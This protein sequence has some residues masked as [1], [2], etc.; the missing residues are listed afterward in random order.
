MF[1]RLVN[2]YGVRH[3]PNRKENK[4]M[5]FTFNDPAH[6]L[7]IINTDKISYASANGELRSGRKAP[8][9]HMVGAHKVLTMSPDDFERLAQ[10]LEKKKM[11]QR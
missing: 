2:K 6:G 3:K 9:V 5:F 7:T 4:V 11:I 8:C 1:N 10:L